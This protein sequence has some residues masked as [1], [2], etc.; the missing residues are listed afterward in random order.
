M[1]GCTPKHVFAGACLTTSV[2]LTLPVNHTIGEQVTVRQI[3]RYKQFN[4][5]MYI[6][7]YIYFFFFIQFYVPFKLFHSY[8]DESISRW[9]E[10]RSTRG[11]TT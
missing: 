6:Y 8:Q 7:I 3:S 10:N 5:Y 2:I 9:G 11:K 1:R 4:K